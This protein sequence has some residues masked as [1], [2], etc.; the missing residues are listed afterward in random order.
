V[1][2]TIAKNLQ[3]TF[4]HVEQA[5]SIVRQPR[6]ETSL[7]ITKPNT[8]NRFFALQLRARPALAQNDKE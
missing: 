6:S 1:Q 2:P 3:K 7:D 8:S 5:N 4:C